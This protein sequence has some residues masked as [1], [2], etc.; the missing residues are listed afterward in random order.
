MWFIFLLIHF[1]SFVLQLFSCKMGIRLPETVK[2]WHV[3]ARCLSLHLSVSGTKTKCI[4]AYDMPCIVNK[5]FNPFR[6]Q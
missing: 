3:Q 1:F 2:K 5:A 4:K 6:F